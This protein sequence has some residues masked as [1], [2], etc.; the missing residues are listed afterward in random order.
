[1][2]PGEEER[3]KRRSTGVICSTSDDGEA[4]W[5]R[6]SETPFISRK[7]ISLGLLQSNTQLTLLV[8]VKI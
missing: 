5:L 4:S 6:K 3:K 8:Y 2:G 7:I 1:V